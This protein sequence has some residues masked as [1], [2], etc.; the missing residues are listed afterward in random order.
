VAHCIRG[1]RD[2]LELGIVEEEVTSET[3]KEELNTV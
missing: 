2:D 3:V 1:G